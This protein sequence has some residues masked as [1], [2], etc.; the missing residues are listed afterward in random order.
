MMLRAFASVFLAMASLFLAL[1]IILA[2]APV[3]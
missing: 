2:L 1:T 3:A